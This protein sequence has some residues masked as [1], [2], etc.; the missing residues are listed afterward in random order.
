MQSI[1]AIV[2]SGLSTSTYLPSA[3]RSPEFDRRRNR[4]QQYQF[5]QM[6]VPSAIVLSVSTFLM[7]IGWFMLDA[8]S[9][10]RDNSLGKTIPITLFAIS[11]AFAM[12]TA[13]LVSQ[14]G[15]LR[16]AIDADVDQG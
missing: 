6:V 16:R 14:A 11:L 12:L 10:L 8:T 1:E 15:A 4:L 5:R 7:A 2:P 9:A 13:L 3:R